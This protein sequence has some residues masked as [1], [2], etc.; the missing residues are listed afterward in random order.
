MSRPPLH[1]LLLV[2]AVAGICL[3]PAW[4]TAQEDEEF[5]YGTH[6]LRRLLHNRKL[7][8]LDSWQ[9]AE[10]DPA[11]TILIL[12]G[13]PQW[14]LPG[15]LTRFLQNGG[16]ILLAS[17]NPVFT[18]ELRSLCGYGISGE[19]VSAWPPDNVW[20][21][22]PADRETEVDSRFMYRGRQAGLRDC[23]IVEP[24][25]KGPALFWDTPLRR[26]PL[27]VVANRGS[28]L[29]PFRNRFRVILP[30]PDTHILARF[31]AGC[32]YANQGSLP[33]GEDPRVFAVSREVGTGRL[34]VP[35]RLLVMG[36]HSVF[37]NQMMVPER[38]DN[39]NL[40]FAYNSVEWLRDNGQRTRVLV[41][42]EGVI[43]TQLDVPLD[44]P[45][46]RALQ[47]VFAKM[48]N[49]LMEQVEDDHHQRNHLN[50][51]LINGVNHIGRPNQR[52]FSLLI[53]VLI[54]LG[55]A[56]YCLLR[57]RRTTHAYESGIPLLASAVSQHRP[58]RSPL[59][60]RQRAALE[61]N[62]LRDFAREAAR[63]WFTDVP[64]S[65]D[66]PGEAP[67]EVEVQG[68]WMRRSSLRRQV[69]RLWQLAYGDDAP[70]PLGRMSFQKFLL[71]LDRLRDALESGEL[72][73][74]WNLQV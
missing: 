18:N 11:K 53:V 7:T 44:L 63:E 30:P 46:L 59:L 41:V 35:G 16:A 14:P 47:P 3:T 21:F 71:S 64:E 65:P 34:L 69:D 67:P 54:S 74:F 51:A 48:A 38:K 2:L 28:Y 37:I 42:E 8:A 52:T 57:L 33:K 22:L 66:H 72:R 39:G 6:V 36:D 26:N 9:R 20:G 25:D 73:L 23:V 68:G 19:R 27:D 1:R 5:R 13:R 17:D 10:D 60:M 24:T 70:P 4:G 31:P 49:D 56:F 45:S 61:Q 40:D 29:E 62:D 12:L 58:A 50:A 43:Q 15:G 32:W 55:F